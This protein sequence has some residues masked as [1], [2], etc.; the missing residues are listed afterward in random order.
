MLDIK[1]IDSRPL[2]K[3]LQSD[4]LH[5]CK[6]YRLHYTIPKFEMLRAKIDNL[7]SLQNCTILPS[8]MVLKL[9]R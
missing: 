4:Y 5:V 9:C 1:K 2:L 6:I 3:C 8:R 7:T